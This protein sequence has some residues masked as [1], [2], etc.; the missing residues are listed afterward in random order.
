VKNERS[1]QCALASIKGLNI[2]RVSVIYFLLYRLV[3]VLVSAV[4][5]EA[6]LEP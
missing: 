6:G 4:L 3:D 5:S 2:P 1:V